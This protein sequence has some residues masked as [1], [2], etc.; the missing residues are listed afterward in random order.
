MFN[1]R[2]IMS[3]EDNDNFFVS[4]LLL[5]TRL[6]AFFFTVMYITKYTKK[7]MKSAKT[8]FIINN[9]FLWFLVLIYVYL[10]INGVTDKFWILGIIFVI[11][12]AIG[13]SLLL[14]YAQKSIILYI[15][16]INCVVIMCEIMF[17]S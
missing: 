1:I 7:D 9:V 8:Y 5:I 3:D 17:V 13:I 15:F 2:V 14:F 10:F 4:F 12:I 6:V 11:R 16:I